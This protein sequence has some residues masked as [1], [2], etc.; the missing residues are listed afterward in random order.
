MKACGEK[1]TYEI[2]PVQIFDK[3]L[4][5]VRTLKSPVFGKK[6]KTG[7]G[8]ICKQF[9]LSEARQFFEIIYN[10]RH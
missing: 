10:E 5:S 8:T 2:F 4:M 1:E 9:R 6:I 7:L 3:N